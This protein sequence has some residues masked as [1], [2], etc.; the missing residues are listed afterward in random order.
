MGQIGRQ[1]T[2]AAF[3][4]K[5]ARRRRQRRSPRPP[6]EERVERP[7]LCHFYRRRPLRRSRAVVRTD[8]GIVRRAVLPTERRGGIAPLASSRMVQYSHVLDTTFGI[9]LSVPAS[10]ISPRC[11]C[12]GFPSAIAR[13]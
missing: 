11:N 10:L 6:L 5:I 8:F 13:R 4:K 7:K 1:L 3:L 2:G 12:S 9:R